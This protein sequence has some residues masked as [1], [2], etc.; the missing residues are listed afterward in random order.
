MIDYLLVSVL[1]LIAEEIMPFGLALIYYL[2]VSVLTF[3]ADKIVPSG[4]ALID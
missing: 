2:L 4:S 1:T 3:R